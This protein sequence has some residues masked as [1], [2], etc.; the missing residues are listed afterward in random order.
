MYLHRGTQ[1]IPRKFATFCLQGFHFLWPAIPDCS[2]R[3]QISFSGL[4]QPQSRASTRLVWAIP[5]SLSA[6]YGITTCQRQANCFLFHALLRCFSSDGSRNR[7]Y[8]NCKQS[9]FA[10]VHP[11][12]DRFPHSDTDGSQPFG[13]SPTTFA[14]LRVLLRQPVPRHPPS[15]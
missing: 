8:T 2:A 7:S 12:R 10:S 9:V 4:L 15:A 1:E 6:T 3:L 5:L 13:G 11:K 14:A